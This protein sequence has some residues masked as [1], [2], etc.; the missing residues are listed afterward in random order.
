MPVRK[1][2]EVSLTYDPKDHRCFYS[3]F[4][5]GT[6]HGQRIILAGGFGDSEYLRE[7]FM[8]AFWSTDQLIV[9]VP[10][11]PC[12]NNSFPYSWM[13]RYLVNI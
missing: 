7:A 2:E 12:V 1:M 10:D 5:E 3:W 6:D 4:F 13:V 11:S 8:A 9:T